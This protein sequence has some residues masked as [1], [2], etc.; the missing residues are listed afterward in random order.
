[1]KKGGFSLPDRGVS[2]PGKGFAQ[3]LLATL[4]HTPITFR[5]F[6]RVTYAGAVLTSHFHFVFWVR[7]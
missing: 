5:H 3:G 2:S 6:S 1:M 4:T 7:A